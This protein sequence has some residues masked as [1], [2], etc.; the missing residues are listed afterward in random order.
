MG[1][2]ATSIAM[3]NW[4]LERLTLYDTPNDLV[5]PVDMFSREF[6]YQESPGRIVV[7]S[8]RH[9]IYHVTH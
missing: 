5:V 4:W 2:R 6:K 7:R 1:C 8:N 3:H 9:I